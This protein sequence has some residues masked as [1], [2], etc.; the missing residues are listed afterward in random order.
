MS[1]ISAK[2]DMSDDAVRAKTGKGWTDWLAELDAAGAK[3]W[4]HKEIVAHLGK[5]TD[6][7]GWWQQSVTVGYERLRGKRQVHE[8]TEGFSAN[9]SKTIDAPIQHVFACWVENKK[10][11]R[12]LDINPT[13]STT[14]EDKALCFA[15]P[16][17]KER[18]SVG[19]SATVND[20][21][22]VTIQHNKLPDEEA[23]K[24]AKAYWAD[25]LDTLVSVLK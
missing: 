23:V 8:T 6:L 18:V 25:R 21:T 1:E 10:R 14:H 13:Y 16:D 7:S 12:W 11:E 3:D 24:N 2:P 22:T 17:T 20:R 15:W 19:F 5:T 4:S 9:K